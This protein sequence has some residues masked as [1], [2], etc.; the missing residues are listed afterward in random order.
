MF[1]VV[2][3]T[4]SLS[5]QIVMFLTAVFIPLVTGLVT[6]YS[7]PAFWKFFVTLVISTV[8]A[9]INE[10]TTADGSAVISKHT[11]VLALYTV[12]IATLTY[13]GIY[14][15]VDANAKLAPDVGIG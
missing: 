5:T 3:S 2:A 12:T 7:L 11:A 1:A 6:K 8:A 13:L 9:G 4:F 14:R 15:P 10:A